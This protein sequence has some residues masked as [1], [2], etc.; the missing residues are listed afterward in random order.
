MTR[1]I[2][3]FAQCCG[4]TIDY[5]RSIDPSIPANVVR[6]TQATCDEHWRGD[7]EEEVWWDAEGRCVEQTEK[8]AHLS[9]GGFHVR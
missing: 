3:L 6:I 7:R 4:K 9:D 2:K 1:P 8:H 5:D